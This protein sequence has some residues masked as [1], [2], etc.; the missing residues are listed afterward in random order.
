[1]KDE[2]EVLSSLVDKYDNLKVSIEIV[3][4]KGRLYLLW[5]SDDCVFSRV[6]YTKMYS[7][8]RG[9]TSAMD[10]YTGNKRR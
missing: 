2:L 1:M 9:F 10:Y 6:D 4:G 3:K 8:I 7:G 5:D